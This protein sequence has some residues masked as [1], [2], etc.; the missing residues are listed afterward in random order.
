MNSA[1]L[2]D[3][4]PAAI[5]CEVQIVNS[6]EYS[7]KQAARRVSYGT[8]RSELLIFNKRTGNCVTRK[9]LWKWDLILQA[10]PKMK[11]YRRDSCTQEPLWDKGQEWSPHQVWCLEKVAEFMETKAIYRN[12]ATKRVKN[13]IVKVVVAKY[14]YPNYEE[15]DH[16]LTTSY[17]MFEFAQFMRVIK[18]KYN[19]Y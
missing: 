10:H 3:A 16:Y 12:S 18:E 2:K 17:K 8:K 14:R 7:A 15:L 6:R 13:K 1:V 19:V 5:A 11:D 4:N 9:T